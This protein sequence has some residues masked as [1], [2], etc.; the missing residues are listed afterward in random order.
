[1]ALGQ[2]LKIVNF[3][4]W[5][6]NHP[7][8]RV[9]G[10][11]L[12]A[13]FDALLNAYLQL[14]KRLDSLQRA[15]GKLHASA[16]TPESFPPDLLAPVV[17]G[18][19]AEAKGLVDD[20]RALHER[21]SQ[22]AFDVEHHAQRIE[23]LAAKSST[24][25]ERTLAAVEAVLMAQYAL[26]VEVASSVARAGALSVD[27][28]NAQRDAARD[29]ALAE[30]WADVSIAW[31]EHLPDT[32]PPN[33]LATNAITGEHWSSRWWAMRSANAFGMM[34]WWYMG[35]WPG[36]P[37]TTPFTPTG[38]PIPPGAMYFDTTTG[39]M[40]VW[41]GSGWTNLAQGPAKATT[42]SLYYLSAASQTVF[43][44][45]V[46]D[47]FGHTFAFTQ[48]SPEG[49][50]ALVNGVRLEPTQDYVVDTVASSVTF[51]R[52]LALNAVVMF[53]A[54]TPASQLAPSG[55]VNTVL[56]SPIVPDGV[57]TVFTGLTVASNGHAVNVVRNEELFV[58][59]DGVGQQPGASYNATADT[60]TFVEA[61]LASANIFMLWFG[62]GS[63]GG[64]AP[65]GPPA[66]ATLPLPD[67]TPH[68]VAV[69]GQTLACSQGFWSNIP[70]SYAYQWMR[71]ASPISGA[72]SSGYT[73][74]D[75]D[76]ALNVSCVVT[77]TNSVGSAQA[78]SNAIAVAP[79]N[80]YPATNL[81]ALYAM[82]QLGSVTKCVR[83]RRA[84]DSAQ[85]DI[86]F[87]AGNFDVASYNTFIAGTQGFVAKWYDQSGAGLDAIQATASLQPSILIVNGRA[88][89]TF[90][91][92]ILNTASS[93]AANGDQTVGFVGWSGTGV[94]NNQQIPFAD[95][96]GGNGWFLLANHGAARN[97]GY[98]CTGNSYTDATA[99]D[100]MA[101]SPMRWSVSRSSGVAT[102]WLNGASVKVS[103]AGATNP[104]TGGNLAIGG[105]TTTPSWQG[106]I[107]EL[108]VYSATLTPTV[109]GQIDASQGAYYAGL[110]LATPYAPS[111]ASVQC[112][113]NDLL[114]FGNI[115][116]KDQGAAGK[117][118]AFGAIQIFGQNINAEVLFTNA[119]PSP[120]FTCYEL[121][122]DPQGQLRVRLINHFGNNLYLDVMGATP[123][124]IDGKK[125]LI[126]ASY[127]GTSP[128][129][130]ASIKIYCDGAPLTASLV[131]NTL[132]SNSIVAS[133]QNFTVGNQQPGGPNLCGPVSFFQLDN[134]VRNAA[135]IANYYPGS[136]TPLP[137]LDGA[138]TDMR[139]TFSE[140][141]GTA[142][143][144]TSSHA[145][146]GTLS[147][148]G[149][150]VP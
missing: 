15:D 93:P 36:P 89:M 125:H 68:G 17:R 105:F 126:A 70:T 8:E 109:L 41:N 78:T 134:I 38:D 28:D 58:S 27:T 47:R 7:S 90:E 33:I 110:D 147:A 19:L 35:A 80:P 59:V 3:A 99:A 120:A 133:G 25:F 137:P 76:A 62:P 1:M 88:H 138:N 123:S 74:V 101:V 42:S 142:V 52:P 121:W 72:T 124:L 13:Q 65:P 11:R 48:A 12:D 61:P 94:L 77:A 129:T 45:G 75:A 118:T 113:A 26:K 56:L 108:F 87:V 22:R 39:L 145:F 135:Y 122:V 85:T 96:A 136:P 114:S 54:L 49:L 57:K 106:V 98:F 102:V 104:A 34:A 100:M 115:L 83:I 128:A 71:G 148:A 149:L 139:L 60:I 127:D 21:A 46:A 24:E 23:A 5:D 84:S 95:F 14:S 130:L 111:V 107:S 103:A 50:H 143:H 73:L 66:P 144:D 86:G 4:D 40:M 29:A 53:D 20:A 51:V 132:G 2:S 116:Q 117:W 16:L 119:S 82:R 81:K 63:G 97:P 112:G 31:A 79:L 44:L 146:V 6:R 55:S 18:V 9:P 150:W 32:I 140:G 67:V 10:D 43:P 64:A 30:D 69:S 141:S 131:S 92:Q 91:G 37:P